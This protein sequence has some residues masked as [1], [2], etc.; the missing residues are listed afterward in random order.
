MRHRG[1]TMYR[2]YEITSIL[3][4]MLQLAL[5]LFLVGL[6]IFLQSFDKVLRDIMMGLVL[7][8]LMIYAITFILPVLDK[9]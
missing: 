7:A 9:S 4:L 2:V 5:A 8:W 1:L 6:F 3:P